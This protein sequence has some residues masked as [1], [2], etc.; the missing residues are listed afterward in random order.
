[1][2]LDAPDAAEASDAIK[3]AAEE[4]RADNE[5]FRRRAAVCI[6][7]LAMLLAIS[8]LGG[9][10]ATKEML[11]ANIG[12]SDTYAFYQA[13]TIRATSTQLAADALQ[14]V[15]LTQP[16]LSDDARAQIQ[17]RLDSY[18]ATIARYQSEP[19]TGQGQQ[20]LLQTAQDYVDRRDRAAQ[21]DPNFDYAQAL[22]QIA[23]V[24]GSVSIVATSRHLLLVAIGLGA[25]ATLLML[26]GFFLIVP[27]P[28]GG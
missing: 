25:L 13:K 9:G 16:G 7:V 21:R 4:Q 17:Q 3:D 11:N 20:E 22:Y 23:I 14:T 15:L 12:A 18:Q 1:M 5:R 8:G 2:A 26:N 19:S 24:L 6:G 27:L 10:N 28:G